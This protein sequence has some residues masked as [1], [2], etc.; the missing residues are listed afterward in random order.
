VRDF[1]APIPMRRLEPSQPLGER[2][3]LNH[4]K[5][6]LDLSMTVNIRRTN[7]FS[8]DLIRRVWD[9]QLRTKSEAKHALKLFSHLRVSIHSGDFFDEQ[10]DL[11]M[12][13][14]VEQ[15]RTHSMDGSHKEPVILNENWSPASMNSPIRP[16]SYAGTRQHHS[17]MP[18]QQTFLFRTFA[19]GGC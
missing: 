11:Y 18:L 3:R 14:L 7:N 6:A 12:A 8:N 5:A 17:Y 15:R 16:A 1:L 10:I 2:I 4:L 19:M 9:V 13:C